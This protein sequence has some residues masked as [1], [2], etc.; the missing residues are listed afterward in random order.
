V[1]EQEKMVHEM[2]R[3][4]LEQAYF[5]FLYQPIDLVAVKKSVTYV[6]YPFYV[7]LAETAIDGRTR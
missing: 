4:A 3:L 2:E 1:R 5:L 7:V 6:P